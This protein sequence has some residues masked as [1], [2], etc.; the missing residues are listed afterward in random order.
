MQQC[1]KGC[2]AGGPHASAH[3]GQGQRYGYVHRVPCRL[4][5][6]QRGLGS[7]ANAVLGWLQGEAA[8]IASDVLDGEGARCAWHKFGCHPVAHALHAL[9]MHALGA[10]R[11]LQFKR[12]SAALCMQSTAATHLDGAA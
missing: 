1:R 3:L 7:N 11:L 6:V 2:R 4:V 5:H 9:R 10:M 12:M 8:T